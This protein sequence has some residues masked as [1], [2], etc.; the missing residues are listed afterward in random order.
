MSSHTDN[1]SPSCSQ[2]SGTKMLKGKD[3]FQSNF[4][5]H[6]RDIKNL[7]QVHKIPWIKET[8]FNTAMGGVRHGLSLIASWP[9]MMETWRMTVI[10]LFYAAGFFVCVCG[11][12]G[13]AITARKDLQRLVAALGQAIP[14]TVIAIKYGLFKTQ[15][16]PLNQI[17]KSMES[18]WESENLNSRRDDPEAIR[19]REIMTN[20]ARVPRIFF[21]V[22]TSVV[23]ICWILFTIA[24]A[25]KRISSRDQSAQ[26]ANKLPLN[27]WYPFPFSHSPIYQ[28]MY[29]FEVFL[30]NV[31]VIAHTGIDSLLV[32]IIFHLCG[33]LE[34]LR[35]CI[36]EFRT[37]ERSEEMMWADVKF[38]VKRHEWIIN[39]ARSLE[40]SF[41]KILFSQL[42]AGTLHICLAGFSVLQAMESNNTSV[43]VKFGL[44]LTMALQQLFIYS[45][46]GDYLTSQGTLIRVAAYKATWYKLPPSVSRSFLL[47]MIRATKPIT[48]TAGKF[49]VMSLPNFTSLIKSAVSYLSVLRAMNTDNSN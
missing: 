38:I 36:E 46:A 9:M 49:S 31:M 14:V 40:K 20:H 19:R 30:G 29:V 44:L 48:L 23:T 37:E 24:P 17:L 35:S 27:S 5:S 26:N 22:Y 12:L 13:G 47:I 21:N 2:K 7:R 6:F 34:I 10:W 4:S 42:L 32:T 25:T 15:V 28:I 8:S 18:D 3:D 16:K 41:N 33:Q 11:C 39:S 45:L 43:F 1:E